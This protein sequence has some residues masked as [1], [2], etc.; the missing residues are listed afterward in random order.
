MVNFLQ[1]GTHY[2]GAVRGVRRM[3]LTIYRHHW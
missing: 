1:S 2:T 3:Y